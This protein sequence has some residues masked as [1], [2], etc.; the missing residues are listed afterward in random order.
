[1]TCRLKLSAGMTARILPRGF[2]TGNGKPGACL[3][4]PAAARLDRITSMSARALF[5][6]VLLA[7]ALLA[8]ACSPPREAANRVVI[9]HQKTGAERAFF[10]EIVAEYNRANPGETVKAVYREGEELRNSFIIAAVAG[11]GPDLVFGPADNVAVFAGTKAIRPWSDLFGENFFDDFTEQGVVRWEDRPWLLADQTGNQ[12]MLVYDRQ[13]V[14]SAPATL[15]ELVA[16]GQELTVRDARGTARYALT[17]NYSEPFF[18]I[19]FL[20]GFG[21]WIMDEAGRPTL[22]TPEMRAAL[23]FVLDLRDK[24][25]IVPRY[26]DYATANLMFR[27]RRAAMILDG[28]WSWAGYGVPER[29]GLALLPLNTETG[30]RCRPMLASKGYSLNV[31]VPAEKWGLIRRAVEYLTGPEVQLQMARRLFTTPTRRA[32]LEDADFRD[33]PVLQLALE[34]AKNSI[35][36]PIAPQLRHIWDG[37]RGPYR[38]VFAGNLSPAEAA[39]AMQKDAEERMAGGGL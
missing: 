35:P 12:L 32:V 31:N 29:S 19:P 34:Q 39:R 20:T 5:L 15:D 21:G 24:H 33:N 27:R 7:A 22:D 17:W 8:G 18:F 14:A 3:A 13:A 26:E 10:E 30:L 9:W 6:R 1:L 4:G 11:Q 23:Q 16:M 2:R 37:I 28:P 38:R 25:G 36:M